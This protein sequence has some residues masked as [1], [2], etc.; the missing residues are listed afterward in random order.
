MGNTAYS[1]SFGGTSSA[2]PIVTGAAAILSSVAQQQGVAMT[3]AQ[4]RGRLVATG[5]AQAGSDLIGPLPNLRAA[6][7]LFV[8]TADAGGPYSTAEGTYVALSAAGSSDPQGSTLTYAWDLDDDGQFDDSTSQTPTFTRVGRDGAFVVR[9]RVT[10]AHGA[11]AEDDAVATVTNVAPSVSLAAIATVSEN[12]TVSISGLVTDPGWL[13]P[14]TATVNWGDGTSSSAAGVLESSEPD[15]TLT[16]S[17]THVYGDDGVFT[18]TVCGRDDDTTSAL[19]AVRTATVTNTNPTATID[20]SSTT[21]INGVP[22]IIAKEG[23]PTAFSARATDPGSDDLTARWT[24]TDG[25]ADTVTAYLNAPPAAD[26]DPSP[27]I[28]PRDVTDSTNHT[29]GQA[30]LYTVGFRSGDDDAGSASSTVKVIVGGSATVPIGAGYWQTNYRPRPTALSESRRQ[31]YL[32]IA[33]FMSLVFDEVTDASTV[34]HAFNV[35]AVNLNQGSFTQ[36]FDRQLLTAWLNFAHGAFTLTTMVDTDGA[37]GADTPF[38]TVMAQAEAA[39]LN[40]ATAPAVLLA[41]KNMLERINQ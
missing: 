40:P 5:T 23:Q 41:F 27:S 29:F 2:S 6:L 34:Q 28:N 19:C 1:N 25:T 11:F 35:L 32:L 18:V 30:C 39:R 21:L 36:L 33:G 15:A 38:G 4:V 9:V 26:A 7:G 20:L 3:P 10:D 22:T 13:D 24:W 8:P 17:A 37:G 31:C 12:T 14:L 16:Y